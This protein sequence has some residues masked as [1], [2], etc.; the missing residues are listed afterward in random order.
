M[1]VE[2]HDQ[3]EFRLVRTTQPILEGGLVLD[4]SASVMGDYPTRTSIVVG[5]GKHAEHPIGSFVNHS[6]EP[7]CAVL[8]EFIIA[9]DNLP[10]GTEVTFDYMENEGPLASPF[11]CHDCGK[12]VDGPPAPCR[13]SVIKRFGVQGA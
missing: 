4:L 10:V 11:T 12:R 13:R 5:L 6:C 2:I 3:G 8:G 9:L 7:S 1:K